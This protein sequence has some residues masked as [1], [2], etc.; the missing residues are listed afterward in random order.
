MPVSFV[1]SARR[2]RRDRLAVRALEQAPLRALD[3]DQVTQVARVEDELL[4]A[5]LVG[6]A[7]HRR[8]HARA[9]ESLDDAEQLE[10]PERLQQQRVGAGGAGDVLDVLHPRQQH[11]PDRVRVGGG[12]ELPAEG[13]PVHPGHADV[14]HDHVRPGGGNPLLGLGGASSLVDVD[15]DVLEGRPQAGRG[16]LNR[17]LPA[18]GASFPPDRNA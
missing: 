3:L 6:R 9:G 4:L 2:E 15:V 8:P 16:T 13:E 14:E 18:T 5:G 11:D 7:A 10:R 12:L 1:P 17:H